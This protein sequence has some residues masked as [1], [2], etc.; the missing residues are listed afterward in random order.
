MGIWNNLLGI[1]CHLL[2]IFRPGSLSEHHS[3][4]IH[5]SGTV[6]CCKLVIDIAPQRIH[7]SISNTPIG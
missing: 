6:R 1:R 2:G 3:Q 7:S 4:S 5:S